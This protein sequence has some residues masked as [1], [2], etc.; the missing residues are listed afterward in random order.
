MRQMI[1][2][3][4]LMLAAATPAYVSA[5]ERAFV[6]NAGTDSNTA[7]ACKR[8]NPCR[9]VT[10]ALSVTD[11]GGV[12]TLLDST[13]YGAFTV[14]QSVSVVAAPGAVA[15]IDPLA[16][17]AVTVD[18]PGAVVNLRGLYFNSLKA[19]P[20]SAIKVHDVEALYV[21]DCVI[22]GFL[23]AGID[24][25]PSA[26]NSELHVRDTSVS[27]TTVGI[28]I[29]PDPST[30]GT[31][32]SI[33]HCRLEKMLIAAQTFERPAQVLIRD[34]VFAG[35]STGL[36]V[37][38]VG[39]TQ[40]VTVEGCEFTGNGTGI[41]VKGSGTPRLT[42][43]N[44]TVVGSSAFGLQ[45]PTGSPN[46]KVRVGHTTFS[47]NAVAIKRS[48]GTISSFGNNRQVDNGASDTFSS[49]LPEV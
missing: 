15:L 3:A 4:A 27:D 42:L 26:S 7:V 44:S 13:T 34:T 30:T 35:N 1:L 43:V 31:K 46:A 9:S 28:S 8:S 22:K 5:A 20:Q 48:S 23:N 14:T 32:A 16:G 38:A 36:V 21:E 29:S 33:D 17:D 41:Q 10:A 25:R 47:H 49:T 6:A 12:V 40:N 24:F 2:T 45:I 39:A 37:T 18:A 11:P 19:E